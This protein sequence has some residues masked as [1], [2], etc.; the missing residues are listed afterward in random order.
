MNRLV[1]SN[2]AQFVIKT[3]NS[4]IENSNEKNLLS[5]ALCNDIKLY[6]NNKVFVRILDV[7]CADGTLALKMLSLLDAN[8]I[9]YSYVGVDKNENLVNAFKER[10]EANNSKIRV[11]LCDFHDFIQNCDHFDIIICSHVTYY[12]NNLNH[13][14][15]DI[16]AR[17]NFIWIA[18]QSLGDLQEFQTRFKNIGNKRDSYAGAFH[19]VEDIFYLFEKSLVKSY[20]IDVKIYIGDCKSTS[21]TIGQYLISFFLAKGIDT[22]THNEVESIYEYFNKFEA[23]YFRNKIKILKIYHR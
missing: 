7:G 8:S 21:S 22:L 17:G 14:I 9:E 5:M 3:L 10:L 18:Y 12:I 13:F 2:N 1:D 11:I 20:E 4:F 23:E 15:R 6:A 16:A 19:A